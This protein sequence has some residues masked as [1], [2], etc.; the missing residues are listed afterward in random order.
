MASEGPEP[1]PKWRPKPRT[2]PLPGALALLLGSAG[3][4]LKESSWEGDLPT[5]PR[6]ASVR[7]DGSLPAGLF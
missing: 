2:I 3:S 5:D 6:R 1:A 7:W 4:W